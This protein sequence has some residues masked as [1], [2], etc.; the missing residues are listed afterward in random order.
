M[1]KIILL[2]FIS[3]LL[4]ILLIAYVIF[5]TGTDFQFAILFLIPIAVY[6]IQKNVQLYQ[7]LVLSFFATLVWTVTYC[8]ITSNIFNF[9]VLFHAALRFII[10]FILSYLL[11]WLVKQRA[12]LTQ[13]NNELYDL[14][15]EKNVILGIAAHDIRNSPVR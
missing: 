1:N 7:I 8:S 4:I 5:I 9:T 12:E 13:K 14:N 3:C 15:Y 6:S 10:Y 2:K 11:F